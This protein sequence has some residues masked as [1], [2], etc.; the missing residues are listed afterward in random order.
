VAVLG[1]AAGAGCSTLALLLADALASAGRG[2]HLVDPAPASRSGLAGVTTAELG[3][4]PD[5]VWRRGARG[6]IT[7]DRRAAAD[8]AKVSW[9]SPPASLASAGFVTIVDAGAWSGRTAIRPTGGRDLGSPLVVLVARATV[10]GLRKAEQ[11]LGELDPVCLVVVG[12]R[13]LPARVRAGR[14]PQ[15]ARLDE[16]GRVVAVPADRRLEVTGLS[17]APLPRSLTS[18]GAALLD[19]LERGG[20]KPS[21]AGTPVADKET[22]R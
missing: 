21:D 2:V 4:G 8:A 15:L 17:T 1:S 13:R 5:G 14:G 3:A 6:R 11:V 9:P 18:R 22:N 12:P 16:D 10:P 7:V 19:L 20:L